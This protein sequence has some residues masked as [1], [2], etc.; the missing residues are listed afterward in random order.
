[1]N[2]SSKIRSVA[3]LVTAAFS[4]SIH[5]SNAEIYITNPSLSNRVSCDGRTHTFD[6]EDIE[7]E[8]LLPYTTL[9]DVLAIGK[10]TLAERF[11]GQTLN[12]AVTNYDELVGNPTN[13][14]TLQPGEKGRNLA[15]YFNHLNDSS[16]L[17]G[18]G[19]DYSTATGAISALIEGNDVSH[20]ALDLMAGEPPFEG[21][22]TV[23]GF[24]ADGSLTNEFRVGSEEFLWA[25]GRGTLRLGMDDIAGFSIYSANTGRIYLDNVFVCYSKPEAV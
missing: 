7:N 24:R 3:T 6:F 13:P 21:S 20:A 19:P 15:V 22:L 5:R 25:D 1:M 9:N 14:L 10:I 18:I 23:K 8:D 11:E 2:T 4:A 17:N 16:A 12:P